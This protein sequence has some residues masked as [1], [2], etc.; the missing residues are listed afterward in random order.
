MYDYFVYSHFRDFDEF[1]IFKSTD[2]ISLRRSNQYYE[3]VNG[4]EVAELTAGEKKYRLS[5]R[6]ERITQN[7]IAGQNMIYDGNIYKIDEIS[8]YDG[9]IRA[10]L[11]SGG[12]NDE[13]TEYIQDREYILDV[14][15]NAVVISEKTKHIIIGSD[16]ISD[17]YMSVFTV[18]MEVVTKGYY[19]AD[20]DTMLK[21]SLE[22]RYFAM[23]ERLCRQT[24][25]RYGDVENPVYSVDDIFSETEWNA[26]KNPANVLS[27]KIKGNFGEN[28]DKIL[29]LMGVMLNESLKI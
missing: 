20:A 13:V 22:M 11:A 1:G 25:R 21:N 16:E 17:I 12:N 29:A 8:I 4:L 9:R 6:R 19:L 24:Y 5:V 7:Y 18:P 26:N 28:S 23:S 14:S 15:Q 27:V 2:K 3:I 10:R